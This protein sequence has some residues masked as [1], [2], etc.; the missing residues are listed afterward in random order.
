M[1]RSPE[2]LALLG[3]HGRA[4]S[5]R[6][7]ADM[8]LDPFWAER[9]G[10]RG[11]RHADED[12]DFHLKY[13]ARALQHGDP[14]VLVRY[15]RW[16]REVLAT[17]GMCTRHLA[18]NFQRLAR[19]IEDLAWPGGEAAVDYLRTAEASLRYA[20]G[21]ECAVQEMAN[22]LAVEV[23]QAHRARHPGGWAHTAAREPGAFREDILNFVS[24]LADALAMG[25]PATLAAH[26]SWLALHLERLGTPRS[27]L[28]AA[29]GLMSQSL[30]ARGVSSDVRS[31]LETALAAPT[32]ATGD[33]EPPWKPRPPPE[34][35]STP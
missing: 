10:T 11:R 3:L 25:S 2:L 21:P 26:T 20:D 1:S 34:T 18:D 35:R 31:Y 4:L 16:L 22:A 14:G 24:Y 33:P 13:L 19:A 30:Q 8:Y 29:I 9:F 7:L 28:D 12:S 27:E 5:Q 17:R 15:A 32:G 23:E 6:V